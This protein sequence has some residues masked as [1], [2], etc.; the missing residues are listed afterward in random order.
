MDKGTMLSVLLLTGE[1]GHIKL[2]PHGK[3]VCWYKSGE[4]RAE[5]VFVNGVCHGPFLG[6]HPNGQKETEGE[7][8][9]GEKQGWW[10]AWHNNG[11]KSAELVFRNDELHGMQ[12]AWSYHGLHKQ[13]ECFYKASWPHG[14]YKHGKERLWH[15]NGLLKHDGQ[16]SDGN[17]YGLWRSWYS[18]GNRQDEVEWGVGFRL[19]DKYGAPSE[20]YITRATFWKPDGSVGSS[21]VEGT[22]T[23]TDWYESGQ[24]SAERACKDG[25]WCDGGILWYPNGVEATHECSWEEVIN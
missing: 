21:I 3:W 4:K 13:S 6:W 19:L 9:Y 25:K 17:K 14:S 5:G 24:I 12:S 16:W 15:D 10:T 23:W 20:V 22:G 11:K 7:I 18:N 1:G 2:K 8:R